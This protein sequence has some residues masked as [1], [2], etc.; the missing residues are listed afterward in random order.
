[1]KIGLISDTH[2]YLDEKVFTYFN[3]CDEIWHLGDIGNL[4]VLRQL[5]A[6]KPTRAVFGNIDGNEIKI[7]TRE[8]LV[9][10]QGKAKAMLI[11]IAGQFEKYT[12]QVQ[13]L[14]KEHQPSILICGHSHIIKVASDKKNQLLYINPGAAGKHGFH[15]MRTIIRF[16]WEITGE[17]K[18]MQAIELGKRA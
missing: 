3:D 7:E 1:M 12:P 10:E 13:K 4:E 11:H 18:N 6:F 9:I 8:C 15:H 17:I 2:S 16:D 5:Q 14:I